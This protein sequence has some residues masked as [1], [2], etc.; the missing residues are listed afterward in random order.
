MI[1]KYSDIR[2]STLVYCQEYKKFDL[3][4]DGEWISHKI[5]LGLKSFRVENWGE[6]FDVRISVINSEYFEVMMT[7]YPPCRD[8]EQVFCKIREFS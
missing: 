8:L 3:L 7:I 6:E 4:V 5:D 2:W 1:K